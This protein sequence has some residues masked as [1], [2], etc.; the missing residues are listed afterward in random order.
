MNSLIDRVAKSKEVL[1]YLT[2]KH[3]KIVQILC[4]RPNL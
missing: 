4:F 1:F 2:Y 3:A